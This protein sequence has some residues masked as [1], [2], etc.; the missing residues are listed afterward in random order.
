MEEPREE[1]VEEP[2]NTEQEARE[3]NAWMT[4][5]LTSI[6]AISI[7]F[8]L[9]FALVLLQGTGLVDL[10]G[11]GFGQESIHWVGV[12]AVALVLAAVFAWSRRGV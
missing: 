5:E 8:M 7:G 2:T 1:S 10:L 3:A 4:K 9:V 6:A 11:D 12:A